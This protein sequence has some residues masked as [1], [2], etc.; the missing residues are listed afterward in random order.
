MCAL[1]NHART[2]RPGGHLRPMARLAV[3]MLVCAGGSLAYVEGAYATPATVLHAK[4]TELSDRLED[5]QFRK[6]IYLDSTEN[7][8]ESKGNLYALIQKPFPMLQ[9]ALKE[10]AHWCDI[11]ILHLNTKYCRASVEG[12]WN[13][14][15]VNIGKKSEQPIAQSYRMEF[16]Y[17]VIAATPD[18]LAV[19]LD[20]TKGP[21]GTRNYSILLEAVPLNSEQTFIH[22]AYSYA[23]GTAAKLAIRAYLGTAGNKKVGFTVT[24]KRKDGQV[25]YIDGLRGIVE[26]NTM[27]YYLAI[28]AYLGALSVPPAAQLEKRL[29][30]WY[31]AV[32]R[33]PRQLHEIEQQE[34]VEMKRRES[35]RQQS[36]L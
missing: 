2:S 7:S 31:A 9:S 3:V 22:L 27:R 21:F 28:E 1:G 11:L 30:D 23:Y 6:P 12:G 20:A 35:L 17:R 34:Y 16:S 33:Y 18:H 25:E 32:E 19:V 13:V 8:G 24:G 4:F 26:R 5:N 36:E 14:L 10:P 15:K 29:N